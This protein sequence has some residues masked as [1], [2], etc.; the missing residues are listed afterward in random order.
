MGHGRLFCCGLLFVVVSTTSTASP[1]GEPDSRAGGHARVLP[2]VWQRLETGAQADVMVWIERPTGIRP[3]QRTAWQT[4]IRDVQEAAL[5]CGNVSPAEV[6]DRFRWV[7]ALHL[8]ATRG[9]I[10]NLARCPAVR[11][12]GANRL[13]YPLLSESV[14]LVHAA[15]VVDGTG[16]D[17]SGTTIAIVD[18][19]VDYTQAELGD[20]WGESGCK[21]VAGHD[22]ADNDE[23]PRACDEHGTN[24]AAI[25]AGT[26][27]VAPGAQVAALKVFSSNDCTAAWDDD[28]TAA[29]DWVVDHWAEYAIVAVN[30]SLGSGRYTTACDSGD[31]A[32]Y[33]SA[34]DILAELGIL[35]VGA[36]GNDGFTDAVAY[37]ACLENVMAVANSY[38]SDMQGILLWEA[39]SVPGTSCADRQPREDQL[40]CI[41]NGGDLI[42]LAAPG[43]LIDAGGAE[44][45]GT[46]QSAPHVA[47]AAAIL[48]E[49]APGLA[50]PDIWDA[51]TTS[52]T[53]VIDDRT[54]VTWTYPRLDVAA[55]LAML[56]DSD[57][58]G[59]PPTSD[60]DEGDPEI[61]PAGLEVCNQRDD[62]CNGL[63][64][65]GFDSDGDGVA[66]CAGDCDDG[67]PDTYPGASEFEDGIDNDCDGV[68]D[69]NVVHP[70]ELDN[71]QGC[72]CAVS[73]RR[74]YAGSAVLVSLLLL[75]LRRGRRGGL[76]LVQAESLEC[77]AKTVLENGTPRG[78]DA[79]RAAEE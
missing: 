49:A 41:S 18:T 9:T 2:G 67:D 55:A 57:G 43:A 12:V 30:L 52:N 53:V 31:V 16:H 8:S 70:L 17:G 78:V 64:D 35:V 14:P 36:A 37:P 73:R 68:V 77:A 39:S 54:S 51:L 60:C 34:I 42:D 3:W 66:F 44:L 11:V 20:C 48:A 45:G 63:I 26:R 22:F 4:G 38:D 29:L 50:L 28:V 59:F 1:A 47:G 10:E 32:G 21:V 79:A 61:N 62:N 7:P 6:R 25:A 19:G 76:A 40:V 56:P 58:D 33:S 24:V 75:A 69:N 72:G 23:D 27:G 74:P 13:N 15:Q 65:E 71:A 46:S 5:S